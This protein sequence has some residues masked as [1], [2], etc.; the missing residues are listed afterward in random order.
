M[1]TAHGEGRDERL[2]GHALLRARGLELGHALGERGEEVLLHGAQRLELVG[3]EGGARGLVLDELVDEAVRDGRQRR[4]ALLELVLVLAVK[5]ERKACANHLVGV[6]VRLAAE[7]LELEVVVVVVHL[8]LLARFDGLLTMSGR[9]R[10]DEKRLHL[11]ELLVEKGK[12]FIVDAGGLWMR[13]N[14]SNYRRLQRFLRARFH[15]LVVGRGD[16]LGALRVGLVH[17]LRENTAN[18]HHVAAQICK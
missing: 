1:R 11:L 12:D 3:E 6:G 7:L 14:G 18:L 16:S 4:L 8:R 13:G 17:I 5:C 9:R 15:D 10:E 2:G